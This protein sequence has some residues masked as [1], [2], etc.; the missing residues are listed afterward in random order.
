MK[1][2]TKIQTH[3]NT[4]QT[5]SKFKIQNS[6]IITG[7]KRNKNRR[8]NTLIRRSGGVIIIIIIIIKTTRLMAHPL[9]CNL[10]LLWSCSPF[11]LCWFGD[12]FGI[13]E[14][15]SP[16]LCSLYLLSCSQGDGWLCYWDPTR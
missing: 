8:T 3:S 5:H 15:N 12:W 14:R 13:C 1:M 7:K 2:T 4:F 6:K 16:N 9:L 11:H 10:C